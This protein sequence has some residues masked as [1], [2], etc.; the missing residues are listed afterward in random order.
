MTQLSPR[1]L[2]EMPV[3]GKSER[4][5]A[6]KCREAERQHDHHLHESWKVGQYITLALDHHLTWDQKLRYF[7]HALRRHCVPPPFPDDAIWSFYRELAQLVRSYAGTEALRFASFE[8]D[9][10][11]A[12]I[13]GGQ[14]R[15][16]IED[17]AEVFFSKMV[18]PEC[19]DWFAHEDYDQL[20]MIRD[21]WI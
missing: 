12:R 8:D 5:Y 13:D 20:R 14:S 10:Y 18:P 21:Q 7:Q 17:E 4:F 19:P 2:P 9:M 15:Q 3:I 1:V 6:H 16:I 11:V